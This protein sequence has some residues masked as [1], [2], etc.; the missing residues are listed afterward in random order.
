MP[1]YSSTS[2]SEFLTLRG[3]R[4]HIRHWGADAAP[5][6]FL[7]HG[8]MDVS[9]SFQFMVDA[10][11]NDWHVIALDWRGFGLSER[12]ATD[13]YWFPDYLADL[14]AMLDVLAPEQAVTLVGHSMGGNIATLYAGV[15]PQRVSRLVNL[16]GFG[17]AN[18]VPA[19]APNRYAQW[20]DELR[21]PPSMRSYPSR[22]AVAERLRKNN[23]RLTRERA[24]FLSDHWA[25]PD[26]RGAWHVQGDPK[27]KIVSANLYRTEEVLACWQQITAPVLWVEAEH[28]DVWRWMGPK[29]E[30]RAEIDRRMRV[31][32]DVISALIKDA[33]HMLH[34][35]QP[36]ALAHLIEDFLIR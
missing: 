12:V 13:C 3:L 23:P 29:A 24:M 10:L 5:K 34:H 22:E 7:L 25:V 4:M 31:I 30:V 9:A 21:E 19:Q 2:R 8:W 36:E 27:H 16:E 1:T 26:A 11:A 6:L 15:R 14:D 18:T 28:T 20:L 17:L 33:G 32:P 35:D